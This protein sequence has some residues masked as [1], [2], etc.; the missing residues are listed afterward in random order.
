MKPQ[1]LRNFFI[2][3][4]LIVITA[5]KP[6]IA[7]AGV[8][9]GN[10]T[11]NKTVITR[12]EANRNVTV[13]Q[14]SS[15]KTKIGAIYP[16]DNVTILQI[17]NSASKVS[18]PISGSNKCK[19]GWVKTSEILDRSIVQG[20]NAVFKARKQITTYTRADGRVKFGY[21]SEGDIF[22]WL[23]TRGNY[24]FVIYPISNGY[25]IGWARTSD[26]PNHNQHLEDAK[27]YGCAYLVKLFK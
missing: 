21:I 14:E 9:Y 10:A 4:I 17:K 8:N 25:K 15:L 6:I 1:R 5:I 20:P 16:N 26:M 11:M 24:S 13:Y 12:S 18:Y 22:Y 19:T 7:N 27:K 23:G 2:L 3:S